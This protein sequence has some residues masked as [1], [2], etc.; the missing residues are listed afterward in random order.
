M[1]NKLSQMAHRVLEIL[2]KISDE[3]IVIDLSQN[4]MGK[5]LGVDRL[6]IQLSLKELESFRILNIFKSWGVCNKYEFQENYKEIIEELDKS[7]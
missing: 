4:D 2:E 6:R 1:S 3:G 7:E 5:L